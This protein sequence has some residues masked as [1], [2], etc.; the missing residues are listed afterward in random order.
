[1]M[2]MKVLA[3]TKLGYNLPIEEAIKFSGTEA[4]FCYMPADV[5]TLLNEDKAKTLK[6]AKGTML[7]GHHSV[8]GHV[9]YNF[10][11]EEVPKIMAMILNNE[12]VYQ[13]SEKSARY[14]KMKPSQEEAELYEKWIEIYK[15]EIDKI[16]PITEGE[17]PEKRNAIRPG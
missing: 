8:F 7:S 11:L 15:E 12:K 16:Y 13:T 6:R 5:D 2:K 4:G 1:M 17:K 10:A 14:T 3:S 9:T